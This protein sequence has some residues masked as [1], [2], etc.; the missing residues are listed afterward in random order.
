MKYSKIIKIIVALFLVMLA[1][2]I[3]LYADD[4]LLS[5]KKAK[6]IISN[7]SKNYAELKKNIA[8]FIDSDD[9]INDYISPLTL[10]NGSQTD[11][12]SNNI[13]YIK[14][15]EKKLPFYVCEVWAL[16]DHGP[17]GGTILVTYYVYF[18]ENISLIGYS[19]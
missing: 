7:N 5:P 12:K 8:E 19:S 9:N 15:D 6:T 18:D 13:I 16:A 10:I 2:I 1:A 14:N 17:F 3:Y 4:P 11:L